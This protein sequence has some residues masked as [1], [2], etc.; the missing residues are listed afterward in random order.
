MTEAEKAY[1]AGI[2]DGE[3]SIM[4]IKFHNNQLPSPC[5]SIASTSLELLEWIKQV[6]SIGVIKGKKNYNETK[7]KNSFSYI[8][9]YNDAINL[10]E[11]ISPYLIINSKKFRADMIINEYK[12]L[13]PRNGRYSE[14]LLER[15]LDFYQRFMEVK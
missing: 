8:V 1:I 14:E 4:L 9:K 7:H 15:K 12:S 10:L 2:I 3:G 11:S 13:T 6:T 5:V